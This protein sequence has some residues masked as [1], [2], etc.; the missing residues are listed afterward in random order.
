MNRI[1]L[2]FDCKF[3]LFLND[4]KFRIIISDKHE[5]KYTKTKT[6]KQNSG[7]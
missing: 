7:F 1:S 3:S 4:I 6:N 5:Q 2:Y